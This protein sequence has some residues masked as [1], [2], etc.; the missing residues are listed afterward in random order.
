MRIALRGGGARA[1]P[2]HDEHVNLSGGKVE[3]QLVERR[4]DEEGIA[5]AGQRDDELIVMRR[6]NRMETGLR[7]KTNVL[8]LAQSR[9]TAKE[10]GAE[11][12]SAFLPR[13]LS[14]RRC[15]R[16]TLGYL[17]F[18][19]YRPA[20]CRLP[21]CGVRLWRLRAGRVEFT[22]AVLSGNSLQHLAA[23]FFGSAFFA[24]GFALVVIELAVGV[25]VVFF[26]NLGARFV[27]LFPLLFP[28]PGKGNKTGNRKI[29]SDH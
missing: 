29:Q 3:A 7:S 23:V 17:S 8:P 28:R 9:L 14:A 12:V 20:F 5:N 25:F 6:A 10:K 21:P 26:Q 1:C 18:F 15:G 22:V 11:T 13:P 19:S 16:R 24:H 27:R 4:H 2:L